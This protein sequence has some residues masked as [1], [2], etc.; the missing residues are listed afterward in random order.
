MSIV[1][2]ILLMALPILGLLGYI[3]Y[4]DGWKV[5]LLCIVGAVLVSALVTIGYWLILV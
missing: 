4:A 2:G 3:V 1:L 5:A